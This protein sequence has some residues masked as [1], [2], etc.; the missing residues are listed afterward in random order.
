MMK[1]MI[2]GVALAGLSAAALADKP[3]YLQDSRLAA[4]SLMQALSG[5]LKRELEAK[6]PE[7]AVAVCKTM[8]PQVAAEQS[9]KTGMK[10]NRVSLKPRNPLL[11]TADVWEQQALQTLEARAAKGEKPE[12]LEIGEIVKEPAGNYYRYAKA[13]PVQAL[14]LSCHGGPNDI[15]AGIKAKLNSDYPHDKATGYTLGMLR[16]AISIKR[17]LAE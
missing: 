9:R 4:V 10:I 2:L 6:G 3:D 5:E 15:G 14:C 12:T 1:K 11:G 17:P 16:G 8:A 7:S 13:I